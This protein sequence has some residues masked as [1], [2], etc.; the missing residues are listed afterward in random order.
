MSN[1]G[2]A[3]KGRYQPATPWRISDLVDPEEPFV[4]DVTLARQMVQ[5]LH[6]LDAFDRESFTDGSHES[7]IVN[8]NVRTPRA[9]L[10]FVENTLSEWFETVAEIEKARGNLPYLI[11]R[12]LYPGGQIEWNQGLVKDDIETWMGDSL[13]GLG[14][15]PSLRPVGGSEEPVSGYC[16]R[17]LPVKFVLRIFAM[18]TLNC[19]AFDRDNGWDIEAEF[20]ED[21]ILLEDLREKAWK[22]ASYAREK[23]ILMDKSLSTDH[24]NPLEWRPK[25]S[26]GFPGG[27]TTQKSTKSKERFVSQFVGSKRKNELSGA[28]FD[29]GFA[30]LSS[31]GIGKKLRVTF[32]S[33]WFTPEGWRFAMMENPVIDQTEGW[34]EGNRFS[35]EEVKFLLAHFQKNVPAEWGFLKEIAGLIDSGDNR[36]SAL[37]G[38]IIKNRGW[39]TTKASMMRNGALSRMQEL[40]LISRKKKGREVTYTLTESGKSYFEL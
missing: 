26:V 19:E 18:L 4:Q 2:E 13:Y 29:M 11:D 6:A 17:I 3:T 12:S 25:I 39:E 16:N 31:F 22:T 8:L 9:A 33:I 40:G 36:P 20:D 35:D 7:G 23:L 28:L 15:Y 32:D 24:V 38:S 21:G 34:E 27:E 30:N 14:E 37:E 5:T 1:P 10:E